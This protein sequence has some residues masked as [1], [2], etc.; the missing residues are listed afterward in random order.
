MSEWRK[1]KLGDCCDITSSKRIF[2]SEYV[3]CGVPF[4]RSKEIIELSKGQ[5]IS[6]A[7]Y[8]SE[9]KYFEIKKKFG[10]PI[11]DDIL[12]TSVGSIGIPYMV[13]REDKFYFKDGNLT[14]LHNYK[15][16]VYPPYI[17]YW[18]KTNECYNILNNIALGAAQKALTIIKLKDVEIPIP[19]L[20]SQHHIATILSR[21]DSLIENYQKQIKLLEEA[22]Q[23]LYKEWF[24]DLRFPGHE[25]TKIV[26]G[27]PEGWTPS[28]LGLLAEFKRG[29]TITRKEII[30]GT[31]PVVAGG[32]DP[33]YYCNKSNTTDRVITVS[34]S[35]ANAGFTRM[36]FEK[37][38][39]SDC[40][41]V[42]T[43]TTQYIHFVYCY[44]KDSRTMIDNL[45]KGAAQPHVYAKDI[46][47]LRLLSPT[48][49]VLN[50]FETEVSIIFDTIASL[51]TQIHLL[52]EARDR[53]LPKLM[54]GKM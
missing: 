51:Q 8:I 3:D 21:Y 4:Y 1:V 12:L 30:D 28:K 41:F 13:S 31:I 42:D 15:E 50:S 46:N 34:G 16:F 32:L 11:E 39:A 38:W 49:E 29:K 35:G 37:V 22:A 20:S 7:L 27:L 19:P 33:A 36:Y 54:S 26:N 44:L 10:V 43:T 23:R 24:V 14:W 48:M 17:L 47:A 2:F 5:T 45:Q 9:N 53:L 6:E 25:N 52:T 40:S 18:L